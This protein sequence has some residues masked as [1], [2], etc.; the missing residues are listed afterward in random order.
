MNELRDKYNRAKGKVSNLNFRF[1][2]WYYIISES[3]YKKIRLGRADIVS[4]TAEAQEQGYN[5][6][7]F[8]RLEKGGLRPGPDTGLP[9]GGPGAPGGFPGGLPP[10]LNLPPGGGR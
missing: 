6:D 3:E 2:D 7:A 5:I 8:R 9:P 10:G 1:G 4:E